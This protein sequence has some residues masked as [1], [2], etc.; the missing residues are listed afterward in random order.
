MYNRYTPRQ[1]GGYSKNRIP[2]SSNRCP[3][4]QEQPSCC[5]PAQNHQD[6]CP[7]EPASCC[8]PEPPSCPPKP[9]D[10]PC[11]CSPGC[12]TQGGTSASNFLSGLLPK[13]MDTGDLLMLL[14]LLLLMTDGSEEA[15]NPLLTLAL[16]FLME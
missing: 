2:D 5:S 16:F 13:N 9:Q 4:P 7:P 3:P 15:P 12:N 6:C 11:Y 10:T 1:D 14:I 8:P